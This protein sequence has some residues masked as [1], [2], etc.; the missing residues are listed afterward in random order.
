MYLSVRRVSPRTDCLPLWRERRGRIFFFHHITHCIKTIIDIIVFLYHHQDY[1]WYHR[2]VIIIRVSF[3]DIVIR[4]FFHFIT[5]FCYHYNFMI[6]P[7]K[8][9][10]SSFFT[11]AFHDKF[12]HDVYHHFNTLLSLSLLL[13]F[14]V[15]NEYFWPNHLINFSYRTEV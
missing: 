2:S 14:I 5:L 8:I 7:L 6:I 1:C 10:I 13:Y 15:L 9:A 4:F 12:H 11:T 3:V